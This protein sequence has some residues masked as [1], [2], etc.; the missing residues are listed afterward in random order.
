MAEAALLTEKEVR[1]Q[2]ARVAHSTLWRWIREKHFPAP[3]RVSG[4][5]FGRTSELQK[6][7]AEL[8]TATAY[9]YGKGVA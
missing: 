9:L 4:R 3:V 2:Y 8:P 5:V 7:I 6:W 1:Q